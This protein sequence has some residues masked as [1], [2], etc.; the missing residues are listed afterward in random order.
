[1]IQEESQQQD[2]GGESK[3]WYLKDPDRL[4]KEQDLLSKEGFQFHIENSSAIWEGL[5]SA[6]ILE[7]YRPIHYPDLYVKI[8]CSDD[9]PIS[10]PTVIDVKK[11]L[12]GNPHIEPDGSLCY[13]FAPQSDLNFSESND[14]TDLIRTLEVFLLQQNLYKDGFEWPNGAHH[15]VGA[16]IEQ[17]FL[18]GAF[19]HNEVCPCKGSSKPYED[20]HEGLVRSAV[21]KINRKLRWEYGKRRLGRNQK[22][23]CPKGITEGIKFKKCCLHQG[24][25]ERGHGVI[26]LY[27]ELTA[28]RLE[29]ELH[30]LDLEFEEQLKKQIEA[31]K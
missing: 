1:M 18:Q 22:C 13:V 14:L 5:V 17:E 3:P 28:E 20:C 9:F 6:P 30:L 26:T 4:Q 29:F 27:R 31:K 12:I 24:R 8:I 10:F 15:G 11:V 23:P 25:F 19:A 21:E 2:P 7:G 16:F